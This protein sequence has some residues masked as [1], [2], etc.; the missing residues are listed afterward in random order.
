MIYDVRPD[1]S[2]YDV[3][4]DLSGYGV[5]LT[6][7]DVRL[8]IRESKFVPDRFIEN[9]RPVSTSN[10]KIPILGNCLAL[11]KSGTL[12]WGGGWR[13]R[14]QLRCTSYD[15]R[16]TLYDQHNSKVKAISSI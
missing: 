7:Y 3:R 2:G 4:P 8:A 10:Q 14:G 11:K 6:M 5:R 1:L 12:V 15:L 13:P 16:L 9:S